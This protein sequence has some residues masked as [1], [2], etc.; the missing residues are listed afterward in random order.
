MDNG[1]ANSYHSWRPHMACY[2]FFPEGRTGHRAE[3]MLYFFGFSML[4]LV[5]VSTIDPWYQKSASIKKIEALDFVNVQQQIHHIQ[6]V[7]PKAQSTCRP[8]SSC[9]RLACLSFA[10][11]P[12]QYMTF[13]CTELVKTSPE[14]SKNE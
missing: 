4:M 5:N 14:K 13:C 11:S 1:V 8:R 10:C 9:F 6:L 12:K 7:D 2:F 3:E